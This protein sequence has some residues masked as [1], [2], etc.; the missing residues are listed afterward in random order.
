MC[1]LRRFSRENE[2]RAKREKDENFHFAL[3]I[4]L[5]EFDNGTGG[6]NYYIKTGFGFGGTNERLAGEL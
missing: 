3:I 2:P 6:V 1:F 4:I 5:C